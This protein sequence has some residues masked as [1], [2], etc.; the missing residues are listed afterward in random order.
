MKFG[1]TLAI[2]RQR[3]PGDGSLKTR[4]KD[5]RSE[6]TAARLRSWPALEQSDVRKGTKN[7]CLLWATDY[8]K[9][10]SPSNFN[11]TIGT[12][13]MVFRKAASST[14]LIAEDLL[15]DWFF[16]VRIHRSRT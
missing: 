2:S 3:M 5:Y 6:R 7:D 9:K 14:D 1:D 16:V 15:K 8:G 4:S 11:N 10:A 12:L 13:R